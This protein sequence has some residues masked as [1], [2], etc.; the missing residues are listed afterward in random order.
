[1]NVTGV[2]SKNTDYTQMIIIFYLDLEG[3]VAANVD[4]HFPTLGEHKGLEGH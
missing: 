1:M 3:L 4:M 2:E